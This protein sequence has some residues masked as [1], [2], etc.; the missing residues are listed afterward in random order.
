[1]NP[2]VLY[3]ILD[4][5]ENIRQQSEKMFY[6]Q[7]KIFTASVILI[8]GLLTSLC[9]YHTGQFFPQIFAI[10]TIIIFLTILGG[11][12]LSLNVKSEK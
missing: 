9:Y 5:Q 8:F 6:E 2:E 12:M 10:R 11:I 1:M 7:V 3:Q 4:E